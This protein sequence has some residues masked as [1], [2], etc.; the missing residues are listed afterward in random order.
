M[1]L[2]ISILLLYKQIT[3]SHTTA[4]KFAQ[5]FSKVALWAILGPS[6]ILLMGV[7][8]LGYQRAVQKLERGFHAFA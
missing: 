1:L 4:T 6:L 3:P 2:S 8:A 5:E 7:V